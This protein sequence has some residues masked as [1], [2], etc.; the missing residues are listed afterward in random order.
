MSNKEVSE[1]PQQSN[2][3]SPPY[4]SPSSEANSRRNSQ[5]TSMPSAQAQIPASNRTK[6]K[7]IKRRPKNDHTYTHIG[8]KTAIKKQGKHSPTNSSLNSTLS[9]FPSLKLHQKRMNNSPLK[10]SNATQRSVIESSANVFS[11]DIS[12]STEVG[13]ASSFMR[14]DARSLPHGRAGG[15]N[16][17]KDR[18][19]REKLNKYHNRKH[20]DYQLNLLKNRIHRLEHEESKAQKKIM[21][22]QRLADKFMEARFKYDVDQ[23]IKQDYRYRTHRDLEE[24]RNR[25]NQERRDSYERKKQIRMNC[26]E[27]KLK[28]GLQV[29]QTLYR[30]FYNRDVRLGEEM[31]LKLAKI[32]QIKNGH[33]SHTNNK[34]E[35]HNQLCN[36]NKRRV[37]KIIKKDEKRAKAN[38]SKM[39]FLEKKE[40]DIIERLRETQTL[41][42]KTLSDFENMILSK[43]NRSKYIK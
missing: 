11:N 2:P 38:I 1:T 4:K 32:R 37:D 34:I 35:H 16:P 3:T 33:N 18:L 19:G 40:Q 14:R 41:Q 28:E 27:N 6:L 26:I 10:N 22:T 8:I 31:N 25:L 15:I 24:K 17:E 39:K 13:T 20:T 21:A 7:R 29:K 9:Y 30:G 42:Q 5:T 12:P 36:E 23:S 43:Q